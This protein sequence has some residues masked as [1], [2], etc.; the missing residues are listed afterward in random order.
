MDALSRTTVLP[1][2][3]SPLQGSHRG[4]INLVH[5]DEAEFSQSLGHSPNHE[6]TFISSST[7]NHI[8]DQ[9]D[10]VKTVCISLELDCY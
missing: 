3:F 1:N 10:L 8:S 6:P 2:F 4:S 5:H 9:T 7:W